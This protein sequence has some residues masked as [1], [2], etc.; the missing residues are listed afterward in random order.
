MQSVIYN[1]RIFSQV[2]YTRSR[3]FARLRA[4]LY[5]AFLKHRSFANKFQSPSYY[6]SAAV[7]VVIYKPLATL[8]PIRPRPAYREGK[9]KKPL[10]PFRECRPESEERGEQCINSSTP[11]KWETRTRVGAGKKGRGWKH[12]FRKHRQAGAG[13]DRPLL[14]PCQPLIERKP[15]INITVS[16]VR[17]IL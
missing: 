13:G 16:F 10:E 9:K 2:K 11:P 6:M 7:K 5:C 1:Y 17:P 3:L 14:A 8:R 15:A 12:R 4:N